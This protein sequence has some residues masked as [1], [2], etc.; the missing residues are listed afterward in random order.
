[1]SEKFIA[2][3][4]RP[5]EAVVGILSI[6]S[7]G[8]GIAKLLLDHNYI[9]RTN[10]SNRSPE[11]KKRVT[12]ASIEEV[13]NDEDLVAQCHYILS[14]VPPRDAFATA[15]R[16][17][18][19][20]TN[21]TKPTAAESMN[22]P[23]YYLDLNAIA[24]STVQEI[25]NL[26]AFE[27]PS[28]RFIDGGIIGGPPTLEFNQTTKTNV[29]KKPGIPL[30]GPHSL[31]D[32]PASGSSLH[33]LLN[34]QDVGPEIGTAS[35]LKCC[36]AGMAKGF[37]ALAI[38]SFSTAAK[39]GVLEELKVYLDGYYPGARQRAERSVVS[40]GPKAYRWVEEMRQIGR[41]F[42]EVG[43]WGEGERLF[44][45]VRGVYGEVAKMVEGKGK[46]EVKELGAFLVALGEEL[47]GQGTRGG[48]NEDGN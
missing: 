23:L 21:G 27:A 39:L 19:A 42:E 31:L 16:V 33:S 11:T 20:L 3:T 29:W 7:M 1:M 36:F 46:E 41:C 48:E 32:A 30:S 25:A 34:C 14:I 26:F 8:L 15:K 24:P 6:G 47:R 17:I 12:D 43:G 22:A 40:S 18:D 10:T 28:V 4:R 45:E 35:G 44:E 13:F 38:Q 37:T 9:V 5:A 2:M